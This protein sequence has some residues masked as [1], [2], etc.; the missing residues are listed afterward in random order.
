M[1]DA[2]NLQITSLGQFLQLAQNIF[3]LLVESKL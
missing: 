2:N 3:L 1:R